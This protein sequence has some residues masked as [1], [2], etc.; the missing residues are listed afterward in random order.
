MDKHNIKSRVNYRNTLM[1]KKTKQMKMIGN[2]N[3][4]HRTLGLQNKSIIIIIGRIQ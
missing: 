2:D 1:Q 4:R 3:Y